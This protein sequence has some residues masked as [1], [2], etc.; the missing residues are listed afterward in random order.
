MACIATPYLQ[1]REVS[2]TGGGANICFTGL[3]FSSKCGM[4]FL[5]LLQSWRTLAL[6]SKARSRKQE[7]GKRGTIIP[8]CIN[9]EAG[10]ACFFF[11][12][13]V[14]GVGVLSNDAKYSSN[15]RCTKM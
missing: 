5:Y 13:A 1:Q 4:R 6:E 3:F 14:S 12:L 7:S 11:A 2:I 9:H 8:A 15:K 10:Y